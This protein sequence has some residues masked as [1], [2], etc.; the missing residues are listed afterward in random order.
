MVSLTVFSSNIIQVSI[1]HELRGKKKRK[2]KILQN[3]CLQK[4][5]ISTSTSKIRCTISTINIFAIKLKSSPPH[6][7][8]EKVKISKLQE[9]KP[10]HILEDIDQSKNNETH[11]QYQKM[12]PKE[13][14]NYERKSQK[15]PNCKSILQ[16][17][18]SL[19]ITRARPGNRFCFTST[20]LIST[21]GCVC[22]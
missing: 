2:R 18:L 22:V 21:A 6:C 7:R 10:K 3:T 19:R 1:I 12:R 15:F 14:H 4:I 8:I 13:T 9:I 20:W 11:Y 5:K 16:L 17:L